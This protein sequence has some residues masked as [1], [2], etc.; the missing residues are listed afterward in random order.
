MG[1]LVSS[2]FGGGGGPDTSAMDAETAE[3]KKV[4]GEL[5]NEQMAEARADSAAVGQFTDP[6]A[7]RQ[8]AIMDQ[9]AGQST[10]TYNYLQG[11]QRPI[12]GALSTEAMAAG[13]EQRQAEAAGT[14]VA[15]VR[16]GTTAAQNRLIR[17]GLRYGLTPQSMAPSTAQMS[18]SQGSAEASAANGARLAE[19]DSGFAKKMSVQQIL[20]PQAAQASALQGRALDAGNSAVASKVTPIAI[21]QSGVNSGV[22]TIMAG[23]Q[24]A[25]QGVNNST[26]IQADA[27][28][29]KSSSSM[30]MI[31]TVAGAALTF[32]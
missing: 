1:S 20:A 21:K 27:A 24:A 14:A 6:I 2:L 13:S 23:R 26:K 32:F 25:M 8:L 31:G 9:A 11:M 17:Q 19:R 5:G 4:S 22:N 28:S 30:G 16:A 10:D 29:E 3:I 18:I 12:E 7:S 15:D